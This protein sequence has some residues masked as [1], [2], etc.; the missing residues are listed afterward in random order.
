M[1]KYLEKKPEYFEIGET[2]LKFDFEFIEQNQSLIREAYLK[3]VENISQDFF[4]NS[5]VIKISIEFEKGSLKTKIKIWRLAATLYIG[6]GQ[7]GSFRQGVREIVQDVTNLSE[8]V[9]DNFE[10][11]PQIGDERIIRYEKRKGLT[12]RINDIYKRIDKLERQLNTL[13]Q[14]EIRIE[15]NSIKQDISNIL[16]LLPENTQQQFLEELPNNYQ[17]NLPE[18]NDRKV[19]YFINRYGLKPE[20]EIEFIN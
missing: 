18:P 13:Y 15:L 11:E 1:M 3:N 5:E 7:Y 4:K 10:N 19:N 6:I 14:Q 17:N 20:D 2:Y 9:I 12:G 16:I 8:Y